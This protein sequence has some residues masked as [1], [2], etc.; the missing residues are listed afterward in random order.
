MF[1]ELWFTGQVDFNQIGFLNT[2]R[3]PYCEHFYYA[4]HFKEEKG[5]AFIKTGSCSE[6]TFQA[7]IKKAV[8]AIG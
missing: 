8:Y 1:L 3:W 4:Y 2:C 7:D 6:I 5:F